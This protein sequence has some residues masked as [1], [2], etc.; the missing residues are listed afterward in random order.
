[1]T[2]HMLDEIHEIP[3][4]V[5]RLLGQ[6]GSEIGN[7]AE[8]IRRR[9]P[10]WATFV[11]RGTSDH[12]ATYARYL[13]ESQLGLRSSLAATS[14]LSIYGAEL[15]WAE[16]LVVAISQ[17]GQS[18][19]VDGYLAEARAKGALTLAVTNDPASRLAAT[20]QMAIDCRAGPELA[21]PATKT[22]VTQL[23]TMAALVGEVLRSQGWPAKVAKT[24]SH[25]DAV[26]DESE[27]WVERSGVVDEVSSADRAIVLGRGH[28][29]ATALETALKLKET[30]YVF[31]EGYS[32]ADFEHGP[33][34]LVADDVPMVLF[35]PRGAIGRNVDKTLG[36]IRHRGG[37]C[38]VIGDGPAMHERNHGRPQL[39]LS[40]GPEALSPAKFAI[41]G[42]LLA[43]AVARRVGLDPDVPR[44]LDKVTLTV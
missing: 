14:T 5:A 16:G 6:A 10:R 40:P 22:Y 19:D 18:P 26:L 1:V 15:D 20:A 35:R 30:A 34:A 32:T 27:L 21:I 4:A 12:A 23:M 44:G 43:E 13:F 39:T 7:A 31:A 17:S 36:R 41:P 28:N 8:Q 37:P 38:W 9:R 2:S 3:E 42:L 29:L 11:G 33:M 25:L 24:A